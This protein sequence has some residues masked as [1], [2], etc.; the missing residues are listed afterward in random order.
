M[1]SRADQLPTFAGRLLLLLLC[2]VALV[3]CQR[4]DTPL[5][6]ASHVWLGYEPMFLSR[7][8]GWLDPRHVELVETDTAAASLLALV[9]G[10]VDGAALT[11]DEVLMARA[12]GLDLV[13]VLVFNVS[14]GAD[15]ILARPPA[16]GLQDM[17][18]QRVGVEL[19]TVGHLLLLLA[20]EE[21]ELEWSAIEVVNLTVAQ[22]MAAQSSGGVDWLVSY[23]PT[24]TRL[25]QAGWVEV[26]NSSQIPGYIVDVLAVRRDRL[27]GARPDQLRH[28][29]A[30][31]FRGLEH[32]HRNPGDASFRMSR[33]LGLLPG[34]V[35]PAYRG[36]VLPD[37]TNNRLMLQADASALDDAYARLL[38]FKQ[39]QGLLVD[40]QA[41]GELHNDRYL[42]R[43]SAR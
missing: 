22:Q 42:P 29:V 36:L 32:L 6:I 12:Q 5:R 17:A 35:L 9:E 23:E 18:G 3:S 38:A 33:R 14:V 8:L 10:Q 2:V 40:Y 25:R 26:F 28:L 37:E 31:H 4:D 15:A 30:A 34:D 19:G 1:S 7:S 39:S 41:M 11:L 43:A 24:A 16:A 13:V 21:A 27:T 20:L